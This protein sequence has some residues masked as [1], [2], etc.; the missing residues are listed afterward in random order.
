MIIRNRQI[1]AKSEEVTLQVGYGVP[2][3]RAWTEAYYTLIGLIEFQISDFEYFLR[4][5]SLKQFNEKWQ[6]LLCEWAIATARR[7]QFIVRINNTEDR[8]I[9]SAKNCLKHS[10][11]ARI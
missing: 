7:H 5:S 1:H 11:G 4:H 3:V 10:G 2:D 6:N 9:I 8:F